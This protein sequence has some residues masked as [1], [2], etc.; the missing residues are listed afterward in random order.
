MKEYAGNVRR[1][2]KDLTIDAPVASKWGLGDCWL[3]RANVRV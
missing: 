1:R 3:Y 2:T